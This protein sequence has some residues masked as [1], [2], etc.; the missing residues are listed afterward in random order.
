MRH[1]IL[2]LDQV[3]KWLRD[4][5]LG[6]V[7]WVAYLPWIPCLLIEIVRDVLGV[8]RERLD[9]SNSWR[10]LPYSYRTESYLKRIVSVVIWDTK[11]GFSAWVG[12][13]R[14]VL[15]F[16]CSASAANSESLV[17]SELRT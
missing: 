8:K 17:K 3:P 2:N 13:E 12:W 9:S 4:A 15:L 16:T 10:S 11:T 7:S 5:L 1:G 14:V 6:P